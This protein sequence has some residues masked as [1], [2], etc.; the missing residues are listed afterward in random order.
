MYGL[1]TGTYPY[2]HVFAI[3]RVLVKTHT[4]VMHHLKRHSYKI[5]VGVPIAVLLASSLSFTRSADD[6][7]ILPEDNHYVEVGEL[8]TLDLRIHADEPINVVSGVARLPLDR[9]SLSS[10]ATGTSIIDLWTEEP[11]MDEDGSI[12]FSGGIVSPDGFFG[13]GTLARIVVMPTEVGEAVFSF[14]EG[15]LFAHDG[16]G[17]EVACGTGPT[18]LMV[19][20]AAHPTPDVNGDKRV[21]L[22]DLSLVSSRMFMQYE[23]TYDLNLDGK[24][25]VA[26]LSIIFNTFMNASRMGSLA[27]FW[28]KGA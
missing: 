17:S 4:M 15:H 22:F 12:R 13:E 9:V 1:S 7:C 19:R 20:P 3:L 27:M 10:L 18:T 21:N 5:A 14:E 2:T 25:T 26:D 23:R 8:V 6:V 11:H 28:D 16:S 24:I